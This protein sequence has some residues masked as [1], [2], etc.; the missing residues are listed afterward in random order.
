MLVTVDIAKD[1]CCFSSYKLPE[2]KT[3]QWSSNTIY[4][5]L[6]CCCSDFV[7][8]KVGWKLYKIVKQSMMDNIELILHFWESEWT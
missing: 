2:Y 5:V 4:S 3:V 8:C 1:P 6:F 7:F